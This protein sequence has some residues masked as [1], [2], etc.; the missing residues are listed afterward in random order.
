[1]AITG[2]GM[3]LKNNI[4]RLSIFIAFTQNVNANEWQFEPHVRV[5]QT[6]SDN[7]NYDSENSFD[8]TSS[9][10]NQLGL[11]LTSN[12][13]SKITA[14]NIE[15]E[16][17]KASYSHDSSQ[18]DEFLTLNSGVN[19]DL[20]SSGFSLI[21]SASIQNRARNSFRSP[22]A[23]TLSGD[24]VQYEQYSGGVKYDVRNRQYII[25]ASI[26]YNT[27]K[28]EDGLGEQQGYSANLT[29]SNG[30]SADFVY[31]DINASF[32]ER[33]NRGNTGES[34]TNEIKVGYISPYKFN[35]FLRLYREDNSGSVGAGR[36][37]ESNS[38]GFGFRWN[39]IPRLTVDL[40]YNIP[41]DDDQQNN[42][43]DANVEWQPTQRTSLL[44]G[45]SQRFY[46][47]SYNFNLSH[48]N[49]RFRNT[50]SYDESVQTF[51]R[52]NF[53]RESAGFFLCNQDLDCIPQTANIP[54]GYAFI[55]LFDL[56][57]AEDNTFS[58]NKKLSWQ[59]ALTLPRTTFSLNLSKTERTVLGNNV[60]T[61][62]ER[63]SKIDRANFSISRKISG[64]STI[65]LSS[66]YSKNHNAIGLPTEA[67]SQHRMYKIN[68]D[69]SLNNSLNVTIGLSHQNRDA[70]PTF[71]EYKENR[72]TLELN[73]VL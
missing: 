68:Y 53:S 8:K 9:F 55:E 17:H 42:Y 24:T 25:G 62:I 27:T 23:D 20:W 39:V 71:F 70:T 59:S 67:L 19:V 46:G 41:T 38:Y 54:D 58:L 22:Y 48:E 6:Y 56:Q 40:S 1:M 34:Y 51:T 49:R 21:G 26:I 15:A 61:N 37:A 13:K 57:I 11:G 32:R 10:V 65:R 73:K 43:F 7:V 64:Y 12:Y 16:A 60:A 3:A 69:R 52:D 33:E 63:K 72:I 14:L 2:M 5:N 28:S 35:P 29:S 18:N 47:D 4:L 44:A 45:K 36:V 30:T 50:I 66:I 31:W